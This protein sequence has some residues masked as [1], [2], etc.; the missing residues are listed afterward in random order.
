MI[1]QGEYIELERTTYG[2]RFILTSEGKELLEELDNAGEDEFRMFEALLEEFFSNGW[3]YVYP[4][5]IGALT[6]AD[7]ITDSATYSNDG[8]LISVGYVYYD[9]DYQIYSTIDELRKS[10]KYEWKRA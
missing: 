6:N 5:E 8:E 10:G 3:A 2:L 4:E 7:I 9:P 1:E